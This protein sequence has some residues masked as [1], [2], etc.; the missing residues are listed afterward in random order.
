MLGEIEWLY[1]RIVGRCLAM[2]MSETGQNAK[3]SERADNFRFAPISGHHQARTPCRK[4]AMS[5]SSTLT[6]RLV[7]H[8]GWDVIRAARLSAIPPRI[9]SGLQHVGKGQA[10]V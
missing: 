2:A 5:G 8:A 6:C 9:S 1:S 10:R 3:Y 4:S 7:G